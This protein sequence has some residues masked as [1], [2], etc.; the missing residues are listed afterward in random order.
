VRVITDR[1]T[2]MSGE[3]DDSVRDD[4]DDGLL[5]LRGDSW[6]DHGAARR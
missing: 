5:S 4:D 2:G 3:P 6:T 1:S